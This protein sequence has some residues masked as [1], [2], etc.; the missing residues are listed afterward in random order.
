MQETRVQ[1]L[2]WEDPLEKEMASHS[3]IFW[4]IPWTD[5][6]RRLQSWS[7]KSRT[8][9]SNLKTVTVTVTV[10]VEQLNNSNNNNCFCQLPQILITCVLLFQ[11]ISNLPWFFSLAHILLRSMLFWYLLLGDF[12]VIFLLLVFNLIPFWFESRHHVILFF[13]I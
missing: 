12:P 4:E 9:P 8:W 5:E 10:T 3:S 13:Y 1:S 2:R 11:N 6:P 7:H